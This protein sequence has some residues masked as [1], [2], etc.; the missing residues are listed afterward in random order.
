[1]TTKQREATNSRTN[2]ASSAPAPFP[3]PERD[4]R[5]K[6]PPFLSFVLRL[7]TLRRVGRVVSLLI[8]DFIGVAAALFT[9]LMFKLIAEHGKHTAH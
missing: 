3:L 1:M 9:A 7:E 2:G 6:R 5:R 4:V 8:L